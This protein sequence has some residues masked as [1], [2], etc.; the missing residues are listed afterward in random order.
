M[1]KN[2][3]FLFLSISLF[4]IF[5]GCSPKINL[6]E[7]LLDGLT[8]EP[9]YLALHRDSVRV[10]ISGSIPVQYLDNEIKVHLFPEYQYGNGIL[11][12]GSFTLCEGKSSET[13]SGP[14]IDQTIIFPYME[15]MEVGNLVINAVIEKNG[16]NHSLPEKIVALGLNTAPLLA[17]MGQ[18]TPNE[19]IFPIGLY[20]TSGVSVI[21]PLEIRGYT[22]LYKLG[23][24]QMETQDLPLDLMNLLQEGEPGKPIRKIRITGLVSPENQELSDPNLPIKRVLHLKSKLTDQNLVKQEQIEVDI[25]RKDWFDFRVLL[26]GYSGIADSERE[27]YYDILQ[28]RTDFES[29]LRKM[30][31][32][33]T[34]NKVSREVFPKLRGVKVEVELENT[35]LSDHQIATRLF[36]LISS[37]TSL[38]GFSP[39]HLIYAAQSTNLLHE[40]EVIYSKL[41][42]ISPSESIYNNLGVVYLN[43]AQRELDSGLRMRLVEKSEWMFRQSLEF[44]TTS[45]ALHNL[46]RS[47]ILK[48]EFADAYVVISEASGLEWE[49]NSEVLKINEGLRGALDIING[50]YRLATIRLSKSKRNEIDLFNMG[51]A[52]F[53]ADDLRNA[54]VAFEDCV[55]ANRE[56]GYGFY[57]LAMIAALNRDRQ[58]LYENLAKAIERSEYLK[59]RALIDIFFSPYREEKAFLDLFE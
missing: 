9:R 16:V 1:F 33:K 15:G 4:S 47:L 40:K 39:E 41:L 37:G 48:G 30:R 50:D 46:G 3:L 5:F 45:I 54:Q 34:Y 53:L 11:R 57:G 24:D 44:N 27:S 25:R 32:L 20:M 28:E 43:Q 6:Y 29:Q 52:F 38:D 42:E 55:F 10:R 59:D 7:S 14:K 2:L 58:V 18:I 26:G 19:P 49:E 8:A 13:L 22:V 56:Y 35:R 12:L 17:R 23:S 36:E 31:Q 51:L 21:N